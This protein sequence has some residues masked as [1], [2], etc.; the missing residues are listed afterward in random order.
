MRVVM[1]LPALNAHVFSR[2]NQLILFVTVF[3]HADIAPHLF[4]SLCY[5]NA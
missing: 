1:A 4:F 5:V 3:N 2:P